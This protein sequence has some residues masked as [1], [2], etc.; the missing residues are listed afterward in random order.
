MK[1]HSFLPSLLSFAALAALAGCSRDSSRSDIPAQAEATTVAAPTSA[2]PAESAALPSASAP[3]GLASAGPSISSSS[4]SALPSPELAP[5]SSTRLLDAGQPPRKKL[6]YVWH[7]DQKEQ[8]SIELRT[9]AVA[10]IAG[11]AQ[12]EIP[13][14]PVHIVLDI[15]FIRRC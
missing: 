15:E 7:L 10:E 11:A 12:P 8:L 13:L 2:L 3:A 4:S 6:R 9:S 14:P 1:A 5:G